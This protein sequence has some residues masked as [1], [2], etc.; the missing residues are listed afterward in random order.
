[1]RA[2]PPETSGGAA[3]SDVGG[4]CHRS[5]RGWMRGDTLA[6]IAW[7]DGLIEADDRN[8]MN[9]TML[10]RLLICVFAL[11]LSPRASEGRQESPVIPASP[12]SPVALPPDSERVAPPPRLPEI[13][14]PQKPFSVMV[15]DP[16]P[17]LAIEQWVLGEP[18]AALER[19]KV[20]LV[21]I[22]STIEEESKSILPRL[23]EL[24]NQYA[25]QG[26]VVIGATS[27]GKVNTREAVEDYVFRSGTPIGFHIAWDRTRVTLDMWLNGAG[28]TSVPCMFIVDR[29]GVL[30]FIG[31]IAEFEQPLAEVMS[32]TFDMAR[33][34]R[35]YYECITCA[36][37]FTH[38]EKKL[39]L[40]DFPGAFAL[41]R[42]ILETRGHHCWAVLSNIAWTL[43]DPARPLEH[44]DL[45]LAFRAAARANELTGAKDASTLDTLARVYF[46]RGEFDE[47]IEFQL[48]AVEAARSEVLRAP[49]RKTL[50]DYRSALRA[51]EAP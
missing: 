10:K 4:G 12:G 6:G 49:L 51:R 38:F 18:I 13:T 41:G 34:T 11:C 5:R 16:S 43:V 8:P 1:M 15:G 47:A 25:P 40:K 30:A 27:P 44:T 14:N 9:P 45:I 26:L 36:W 3:T 50:E 20:Y 29:E 19:G 48:R 7:C 24:Q 46:V 23:T 31:G 2:D 21:L 33:A 22:W 17:A 28:R 37:A 32:G 39:E 35:Q 42:E